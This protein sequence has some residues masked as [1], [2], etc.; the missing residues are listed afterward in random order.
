MSAK[1]EN[2]RE[3]AMKL[4]RRIALVWLACG[5]L[6]GCASA[7]VVSRDRYSGPQLPR[8]DRIL[9][10]DFAVTPEKVPADSPL[11]TQAELPRTSPS[12]QQLATGRALGM[13]IAKELVADLQ[14]AGLPAVSAVGQPAP[15]VD[16]IVIKGYFVSVEE[17]SVAERLVLG[18]GAGAAKL[19]TVVEAYQMTPLGLRRLAGG[20]VSSGEGRAPGLA[21]PIAVTAATANPI[22]LVVGGAI[23]VSGELSGRTTIEGAAQRTANEIATQFEAAAQKQ[24]WI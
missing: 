5:L 8:P 9:V 17:G 16:D 20:E 15:T 21:L 19:A 1:G 23:N 18:F 2:V 22:G 13:Q 10:E 12:P 6:T 11:A 4:E 3:Q 24:G 14:M 7:E